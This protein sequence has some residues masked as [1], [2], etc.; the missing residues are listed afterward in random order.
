MSIWYKPLT[1]A[2]LL[3]RYKIKTIHDVLGIKITE[4]GEDYLR[5]TMPVDSRTHQPLGI[6]H[7]E[8]PACWP[9]HWAVWVRTFVW[10]LH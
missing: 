4:L 9:R 3:A 5:G 6:M 1:L 2:D 10:I 8:L 7:G